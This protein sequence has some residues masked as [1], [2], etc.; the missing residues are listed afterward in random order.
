MIGYMTEWDG[1]EINSGF[2]HNSVGIQRSVSPSRARILGGSNYD[3]DGMYTYPSQQQYSAAFVDRNG[4]V[5]TRAIFQRLGKYGWLKAT[6]ATGA[7]LMNWAKL[8]AIDNNYDPNSWISSVHKYTLSFLASEF[9]YETANTTSNLD[10][11]NSRTIINNGNAR[12]SWLTIY[13]TSEISLFLDI[14]I[15]RNSGSTYNIPKYGA[16][17][18]DGTGS[19]LLTYNSSKESGKILA[20]DFKSNKIT[21]NGSDN[22]GDLLLS[23]NQAD[24]GFLYPGSNRITFS[25]TVNGSI[26]YRGAY[27]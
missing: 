27:V 17:I 8:V 13:I 15:S 1:I 12:S 20:I 7:N 23:N 18:Y 24:F 22:Y 26:V 6:S 14:K 25:S 21:I 9:W 11:A 3:L 16:G 2:G 4:D 19:Q 10:P 5:N